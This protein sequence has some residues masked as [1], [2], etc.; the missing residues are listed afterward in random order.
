MKKKD[1]FICVTGA[2]V[3]Q[4]S[5]AVLTMHWR[6]VRVWNRIPPA[7]DHAR[8]CFSSDD[9]APR[10]LPQDAGGTRKAQER[11]TLATFISLTQN[12]SGTAIRVN[13]DNVL[14]IEADEKGSVLISVAGATIAV[15]EKPDRII[16]LIRDEQGR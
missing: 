2:D 4:A 1:E 11:T 9:G 8:N 5:A 14:T 10:R 16:R 3:D 6:V 15:N 12:H 7:I 13:M